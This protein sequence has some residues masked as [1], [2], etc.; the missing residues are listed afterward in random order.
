MS[1][2]RRTASPEQAAGLVR[3]LETAERE[4]RLAVAHTG[5][6]SLQRAGQLVAMIKRLQM[7]RLELDT[8]ALMRGWQE[9]VLERSNRR[10]Q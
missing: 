5:G 9:Q 2:L 1:S 4:L 6:L 8:D 10:D 7:T 3:H